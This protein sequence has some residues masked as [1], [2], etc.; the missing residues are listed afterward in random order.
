MNS[1]CLAHLCRYLHWSAKFQRAK[2]IWL[3]CW[4]NFYF[5]S[6]ELNIQAIT[7]IPSDLAQRCRKRYPVF[8]QREFFAK[9]IYFWT[10]AIIRQNYITKLVWKFTKAKPFQR[11]IPMINLQLFCGTPVPWPASSDPPHALS[12][13]GSKHFPKRGNFKFVWSNLV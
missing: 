3:I 4:L 9:P 5:C 13:W 11:Y 6:V 1:T 7:F 12:H 2:F 10:Y 8:H